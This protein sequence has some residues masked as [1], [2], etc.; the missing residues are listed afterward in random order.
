M[1]GGKGS[2]GP[3]WEGGRVKGAGSGMG[4]A[5][6]KPRRSVE[7]IKICSIWMWVWGEPPESPRDLGH[8]RLSGHNAD[9][10]SQNS[11]QWRKKLRILH[12]HLKAASR[13]PASRHLGV[14]S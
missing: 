9:D 2:E 8:D 1:R 5:A 14:R 4:E 13:I 6:E 10:L 12:L 7:L 3:G 11:Q